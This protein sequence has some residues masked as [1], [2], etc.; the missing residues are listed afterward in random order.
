MREYLMGVSCGAVADACERLH[1]VDRRRRAEIAELRERLG[2]DDRLADAARADGLRAEFLREWRSRAA[3]F[4]GERASILAS[5]SSAIEPRCRRRRARVI[6]PSSKKRRGRRRHRKRRCVVSGAIRSAGT[7]MGGILVEM[8]ARRAVAGAWIAAFTVLPAAE[9]AGA[10]ERPIEG[11][12]RFWSEWASARRLRFFSTR[13]ERVLLLLPENRSKPERA[14]D[15]VERAL[16]RFDEMLPAPAPSG[17][18]SGSDGIAADPDSTGAEWNWGDPSHPL[19]SDAIVVGLFRDPEEYCAALDEIGKSF[20]YLLP[21]IESG[22]D[23]PGCILERPL[24]G[25]CIASVPGMEEWNPDNELVHRAAQLA[26]LR[27]FGQQPVWVGLGVGWNVEFDVLENIYCFPWR[28]GFVSVSEHGGW[29]ADLRKTF[30]KREKQ[31]LS[32][33]ELADVRRGG[34][35][36]DQAAISWGAVRFLAQHH[37]AELPALLAELHALRDRLG[38][39]SDD[40]G[41]HWTMPA[42]YV[43]PASEQQSALERIVAED[44]LAQ[45]SDWFRLGRKWKKPGAN[46]K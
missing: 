10:P 6:R 8:R 9:A 38:R 28:N 21:W 32:A 42:D 4:E 24:F 37:P 46:A 41:R 34:F 19:D 2:I 20:P 3:A 17:G 18:A 22:R 1:D 16:A 25:A 31:P 44:V 5:L 39:I 40:G 7:S 45:A 43:L 36:S 29:E 14:L 23:D 11:A 35:D 30:S 33:G 15:L 26:M 13:D 12:T 27:R